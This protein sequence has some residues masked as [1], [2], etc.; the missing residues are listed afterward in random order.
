MNHQESTS[1]PSAST[2]RRL[3]NEI[4]GFGS[5]L[6]DWGLKVACEGQ[7]DPRRI[8]AQ[9]GGWGQRCSLQIRCKFLIQLPGRR[10]FQDSG[11]QSKGERERKKKRKSVVIGE[12]IYSRAVKYLYKFVKVIVS[13]YIFPEMT[14]L[15]IENINVIVL[16]VVEVQV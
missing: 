1:Q 2:R 6:Q 4:I 3:R 10:I 16:R 15:N 8:F 11:N 5:K 12:C 7:I 13:Y 9:I 14:L